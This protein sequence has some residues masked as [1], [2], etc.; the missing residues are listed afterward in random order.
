LALFKRSIYNY[1]S[2]AE[3]ELVL[4]Y[5]HNGERQNIGQDVPVR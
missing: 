2:G 3:R 1:S 4:T 5:A